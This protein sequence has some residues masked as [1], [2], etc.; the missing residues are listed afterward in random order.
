MA[1]ASVEDL[2]GWIGP[3]LQRYLTGT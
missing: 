3:T 2:V 1:S